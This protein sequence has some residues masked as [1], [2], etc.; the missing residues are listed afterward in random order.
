MPILTKNEAWKERAGEKDFLDGVRFMGC[1]NA[2]PGV[3]PVTDLF[4]VRVITGGGS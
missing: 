1:T 4:V 3:G 2:D